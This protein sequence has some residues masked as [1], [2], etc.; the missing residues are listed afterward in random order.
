M[1][2]NVEATASQPLVRST[3]ARPGLPERRRR[4]ASI[5]QYPLKRGLDVV[6][7]SMLLLFLLPFGILI[8]GVIG[9][10][11]GPVFFRSS[12]I[13]MNGRPFPMYKFRTMVPDAERLLDAWLA[14]DPRTRL[15]YSQRYKLRGDP[16]VTRI[17]RLLRQFSLD[18]LPQ[19]INVV[20]GEMS[21]IGPRPRLLRE[22]A[23]AGNYNRRHFEAYYLCRPGMT[24]LW[25]VSG[26]SNTDYHARIRLDA[27][28]VRQMSLAQ[29]LGILARTIPVVLMGRGDC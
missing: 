22:I 7:A 21:L 8:A 1:D 15:D 10:S 11:G 28:Y 26:R 4:T 20:R 9:L 16:R 23:D 12:R 29:D 13:G 19:L 17:G 24:G 3:A 2:R 27:L 6:A 14:N 25:Q 5:R 18:E